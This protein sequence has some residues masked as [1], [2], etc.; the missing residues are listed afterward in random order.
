MLIYNSEVPNTTGR[1][2]KKEEEKEPRYCKELTH[3][4]QTQKVN[5]FRSDISK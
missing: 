3:F 2:M 1:K 5:K 4:T